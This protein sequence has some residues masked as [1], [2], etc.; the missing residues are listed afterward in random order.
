LENRVMRHTTTRLL[1]IVKYRGSAHGSNEYPFLIGDKGISV[2]P[3]TTLTLDFPIT[4]ERVSTGV[5]RLDT[6]LNGKGYFR[7]STVLVSGPVGSGKSSLAAIFAQATCA[8]GERCLY[9]SL[10]EPRSQIVRNMQSIGINLQPLI[11]S[12]CLHFVMSRPALYGLEMHLAK[13]H[14]AVIEFKPRVVIFDPIS[15][16]QAIED[17]AALKSM[18]LRLVNFLRSQEITTHFVAL[19]ETTHETHGIGISSL[20]DSWV[21][22]RNVE[23][24]GERNRVLLVLK[25][26]G[27]AHSNQ[28]REFTLNDHGIELSDVYVGSAGVLTGSARMAQEAQERSADLSHQFDVKYRSTSL[29]AKRRLKDA[30]IAAIEAEFKVGEAEQS[31]LV[32]LEQLGKLQ[33]QETA[34][35]MSTLRGSDVSLNVSEKAKKNESSP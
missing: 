9:F 28:L 13:F 3:V 16:L 1:R 29:E 35:K 23:T 17:P 19:T 34:Q 18:L 30:K 14:Q 7:G 2:L 26:R 15:T 6:M 32:E 12:G 25:S 27:M 20:I 33:M 22:L 8:R 21:Q 11:D 24:N 4:T 31:R 10:E 5:P